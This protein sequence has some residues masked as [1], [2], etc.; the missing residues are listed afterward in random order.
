MYCPNSI[1][2]TIQP[3]LI[4]TSH[5]RSMGAPNPAHM[6][7]HKETEEHNPTINPVLNSLTSTIFLLHNPSALKRQI[8]E[9]AKRY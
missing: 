2:V 1:P 5:T 8:K 9:S 4:L 7:Q 3:S 6:V